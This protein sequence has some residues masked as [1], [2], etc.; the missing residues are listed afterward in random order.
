MNELLHRPLR[1]NS[2]GWELTC[3]FIKVSVILSSISHLKTLVSFKTHDLGQETM[4]YGT[5]K[6]MYEKRRIHYHPWTFI[7]LL[8]NWILSPH[9]FLST[10]WFPLFP[11]DFALCYMA[12]L[13]SS[14]SHSSLKRLINVTLSFFFF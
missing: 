11:L 5:T 13:L 3:F 2:A 9:G 14:T 8:T 1:L 4:L 6:Y 12:L 7:F 10:S